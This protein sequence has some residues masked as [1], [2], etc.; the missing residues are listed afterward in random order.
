LSAFKGILWVYYRFGKLILHNI[1]GLHAWFNV[2]DIAI[3]VMS[4]EEGEILWRCF[5]NYK[6][7]AVF[8]AGYVLGGGTYDFNGA[9]TIKLCES[10]AP[11]VTASTPTDI[12]NRCT[13]KLSDGTVVIWDRNAQH[14]KDLKSGAALKLE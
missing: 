12:F 13:K 9:P 4:L 2:I 6:L 3:K 7:G 5:M 8:I 11:R 14:Q 1:C 10:Q